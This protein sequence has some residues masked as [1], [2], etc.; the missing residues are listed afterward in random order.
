MSSANGPPTVIG[1]A[2][3]RPDAA[4]VEDRRRAKGRRL[5]LRVRLTGGREAG[6][7]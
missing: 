6:A 1:L 4:P 5:P 3:Q 2:G 7:Q